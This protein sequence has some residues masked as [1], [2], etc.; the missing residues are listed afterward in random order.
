MLEPEIVPHPSQEVK[1]LKQETTFILG[2]L[3]AIL[4][5]YLLVA[6]LDAG[7]DTR[8]ACAKMY[9]DN[10]RKPPAGSV[11]EFYW[12]EGEEKWK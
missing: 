5:A 7:I 9:P 11:C 8:L 1:V 3:F 12:K 4:L 2:C 6:S 10:G